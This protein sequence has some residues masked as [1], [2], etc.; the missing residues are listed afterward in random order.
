MSDQYRDVTRGQLAPGIAA[1][2]TNGAQREKFCE[3]RASFAKCIIFNNK[4][5][6]LAA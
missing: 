3:T 6:H 4:D 1:W 5:Y 2:G